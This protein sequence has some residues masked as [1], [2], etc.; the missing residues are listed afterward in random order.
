MARKDYLSIDIG[1]SSIKFARLNRSGKIIEGGK[2]PSPDNQKDFLQ[3]VDYIINKYLSHIRGV[4]FCCPGTVD[5]WTSEISFGGALPYLDGLNLADHV[6]DAFDDDLMVA[7]ENDGKCAALAELWLGNLKGIDNGMA[8]VLGTGIGGG[9]ILNGQL[10]RGTHFQAGELSFMRSYQK[11]GDVQEKMYGGW[12][13]AVSMVQ[14]IARL[15]DLDLDDGR[16]VFKKIN[17]GE[18]VATKIFRDYC[19]RIA[20]QLI[21]VQAV[22]DLQRY[23]IGGGISAQPIVAETIKEEYD[24]IADDIDRTPTLTRPEIVS[25]HFGNGANIHGALYNLFLKTNEELEE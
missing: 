24:K 7:V 18:P 6:A 20:L 19:H 13:S 4:A 25:A 15:Y 2:V 21:D 8:V 9:L 1:G 10:F 22:L 14:R 5:P 3:R 12:G 23:V 16:A 11:Q 17:D